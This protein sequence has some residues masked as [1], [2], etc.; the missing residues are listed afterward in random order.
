MKLKSS[1]SITLLLFISLIFFLPSVSSQAC[2]KTCG[3]QPIQYP[4]GSGPGCGDPRFQKY[5]T[6]NQEKLTLTT[7][8][9]SYP[10][11]TI[12]YNNQALYIQDPSMSTCSATQP[13]KGF[14]LD[15][16]APFT[17]LD[18][19]VFALLDCSTSSSPLY[20]SKNHS[21]GTNVLLCENEGAPV[22]SLLYSCSP[23]STLNL[24]ISTC[25]VYTPV[26]LGPAFE[27]DL[28]KLQCNSYA[29]IYSFNGQESNPA[30]WEYGVALKYKFSVKNDYPIDCNVCERSNGACGYTGAYNAF[31]CNCVNGVNT[32][33]DCYFTASWNNSL[34][35]LPWQIGTWLIY[36][37]WFLVW[38][39]F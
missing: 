28:Q 17:F 39:F 20:K 19:N 23:I 18:D 38:I 3:N 9:G 21:N 29:A 30:S 2:K 5:V 26:D 7:H 15:W 8:T 36:W 27:M 37:A 25:C 33:T 10:V 16:N 34:K 4:F 31:V 6:C 32:T 24:P 11:D 22:C 1:S 35:L 13:S 14:G 12:D